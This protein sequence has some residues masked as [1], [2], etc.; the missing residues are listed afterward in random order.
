MNARALFTP[1]LNSHDCQTLK[2]VSIESQNVQGDF[3]NPCNQK[4]LFDQGLVPTGDGK[5]DERFVTGS[6]AQF[7]NKKKFF[8]AGKTE[9]L[10]DELPRIKGSRSTNPKH[11]LDEGIVG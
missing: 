4:S 11:I 7:G 5:Q 8:D 10:L 1:L 3:Y 2:D 9:T 6:R